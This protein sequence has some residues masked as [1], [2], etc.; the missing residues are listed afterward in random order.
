MRAARRNS[1][2]VNVPVSVSKCAR[3]K[4]MLGPERC[5]PKKT[6]RSVAAAGSTARALAKRTV[7]RKTGWRIVGWLWFF[8]AQVGRQRIGLERLQA[9]DDTLGIQFGPGRAR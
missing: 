9:G 3:E 5:V 8:F 2:F 7:A 4:P 6:N 1:G